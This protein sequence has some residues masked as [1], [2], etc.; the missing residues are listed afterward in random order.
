M[1]FEER[2]LKEVENKC[3]IKFNDYNYSNR[4][5][6]RIIFLI[7]DNKQYYISYSIIKDSNV[8]SILQIDWT[9]FDKSGD[10]IN[11][12]CFTK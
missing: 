8:K 4:E 3:N 6:S 1:E 9:L 10:I 7:K 11:Y 5:D 12:S 2:V